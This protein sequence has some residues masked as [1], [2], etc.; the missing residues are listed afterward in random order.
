MVW[1]RYAVTKDC[2]DLE[3]VARLLDIVYSE[4]YATLTALGR[5]AS[6]FFWSGRR[7]GI[8]RSGD[9]LEQRIAESAI[10]W[11]GVLPRV[12]SVDMRQGTSSSETITNVT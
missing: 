8:L 12:Q 10:L 5:K 3:A 6:T 9:E 1:E 11:N 4:D 2:K 7:D